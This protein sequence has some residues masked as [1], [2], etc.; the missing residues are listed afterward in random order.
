MAV[1]SA[2]LANSNFSDRSSSA[3]ELS[4]LSKTKLKAWKPKI[5]NSIQL[6]FRTCR[7][8]V[9]IGLHLK[10]T[11]SF[12]NVG[13]NSLRGFVKLKRNWNQIITRWERKCKWNAHAEP[14]PRQLPTKCALFR[15]K[16]RGHWVQMLL[17]RHT[18]AVDRN[19][20]MQAPKDVYVH[21][22]YW[23]T[24]RFRGFTMMCSIS[25]CFTVL[26]LLT[27][28]PHRLLYLHRIMLSIKRMGSRSCSTSSKQ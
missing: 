19:T 13:A 24:Q 15:Q 18:P 25:L 5:L 14:L 12:I 17:T 4:M 26:Y 11:A 7:H 2:V 6:S 9:Y 1:A 20:F 28:L 22:V 8:L 21:N 10:V 27:Y 3:M 23:Y 16:V